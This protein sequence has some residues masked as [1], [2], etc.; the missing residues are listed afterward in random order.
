MSALQELAPVDLEKAVTALRT[1]W[2]Q[3]KGAAR[4]PMR[5]SFTPELLRP[6]LPH[7]AVVEAV[8]AP[9]RFRIRLAGTAA[10]SFAGRDLTGKFLDEVVA[11]DQYDITVAPYRDAMGT[12][13]PAEDDVLRGQFQ[14]EDGT[15]LPVR[16]LVLPC[17]SNGTDVDRFVVGLFRYRPESVL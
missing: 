16:R 9:P 7:I 14:G 12:G 13:A 8:G 2:Q 4:V 11:P 1:L 6:W 3:I 17:S 5:D 15:Y 10:V